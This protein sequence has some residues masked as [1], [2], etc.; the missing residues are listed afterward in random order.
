[1]PKI[2]AIHG[3]AQQV[4][5]EDTLRAT[6][7]PALRS[8]LRR[9][10]A[11]LPDDKDLSVAFYGDLF[12]KP[13]KRLGDKAIDFAWEADD[14][15]DP[16]EQDFLRAWWEEAA[17]VD[18]AV[19][20]PDERGKGTPQFVQS[21]LNALSS[22]KFFAGIAERLLI[23]NLKQVSKY[24]HED[25]VRTTVQER[26]AD[27]IAPDTKVLLGHSL[28]SIVAYEALCAHPDWPVRT[29]VTLG[30]PLGIRNLIFERL[31]P[32]P[33]NGKGAWPRGV[34][35]WVN[36]SDG[37]DIVALTKALGPMFSGTIEDYSVNNDANAHDVKPYLTAAETGRAIAAGLAD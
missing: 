20:P 23:G 32:A 17:R 11:E 31:R 18:R 27:W 35:R 34:V 14:V 12:R 8:G 7:L 9:A 2:V 36:V 10:K 4:E 21:A 29:L 25:S 15:T 5:G 30:S 13:G 19:P 37:G 16:W 24:F 6:W 22:S 26:V 33:V 28:G 1:M 3:I